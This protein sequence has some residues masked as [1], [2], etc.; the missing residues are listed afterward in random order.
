MHKPIINGNLPF[1]PIPS[2]ID[3]PIYKLAKFLVPVLSE[4][5]QNE[6]IV[7]DFF[8]F[9]D[10]ILTENNDIYMASLDVNALFTNIPLDKTIDI[11][12]KKLP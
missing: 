3:T 8:T 2:A 9:V 10:E 11:S 6:F 4:I 12:I 5:T 7:K 1:R